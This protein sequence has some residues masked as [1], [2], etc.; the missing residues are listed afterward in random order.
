MNLFTVVLTQNSLCNKIPRTKVERRIERNDKV[1]KVFK[2]A[3][4]NKIVP[5]TSIMAMSKIRI[6]WIPSP[7]LPNMCLNRHSI[8]F[9]L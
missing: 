7:S 3:N 9:I 5:M 1:G 2:I 8:F 6:A 4:A